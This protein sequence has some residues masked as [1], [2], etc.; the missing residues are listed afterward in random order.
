MFLTFRENGSLS[1]FPIGVPQMHYWGFLKPFK[2]QLHFFFFY[3]SIYGHLRRKTSPRCKGQ[4]LQ[5]RPRL[6]WVIESFL[7]CA[8]NAQENVS[9][10]L[11]QHTCLPLS[12]SFCAETDLQNRQARPGCWQKDVH[13]LVLMQEWEDP[14][15]TSQ[16]VRPYVEL[17][18]SSF[19]PSLFLAFDFL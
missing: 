12:G 14:C 8:K 6:F 17:S 9:L 3:V 19:L 1:I 18:S 13:G 10:V 4:F 16:E 15:G 2:N 5:T 11:P 7:F